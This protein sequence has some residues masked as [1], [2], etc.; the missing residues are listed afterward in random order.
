MRHA[1]TMPLA[2]LAG[3]AISDVAF[4]LV[5]AAIP[6]T[7]S[8]SSQPG[9]DAVSVV[10][11]QWAAGCV[12]FRR[13]WPLA[14]YGAAM[15]ALVPSWVVWGAPEGLGLLLPLVVLGYAL[16]R[17]AEG[18]RAYVGLG[19]LVTG[20]ALHDVLDPLVDSLSAF[21]GAAV[22]DALGVLAWVAGALVR[23]GRIGAVE[24]RGRRALEER[25]RLARELHDLIAHGMSVMVIQAEAAAEMIEQGDPGRAL[26]AIGRVQAT[27]REGLAEVRRLVAVLRGEEAAELAPQPGVHQLPVL[28]RQADGAGP[29][30]SLVESGEPGPIADGISLALYRIA[31][32]AITNALRHANASRIDVRMDYDDPLEL[33]IA[34]DGTARPGAP[35]EP[36]LG[37]RGMR[38]RA[39]LYGGRLVA[40]PGES[41]GFVVVASIPRDGLR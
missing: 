25:T 26:T 33:R 17:Y 37:I 39:V 34:D 31:Q 4:A 24:R 9:P 29:A 41:G 6:L 10:T 13:R 20:M 21:R 7:D 36:G 27:G 14:A 28:V 19:V 18:R 8:W 32:E 16:G 1:L 23:A 22:F 30:V 11:A 12:V 2:S 15:A 40:A 3:A 5:L 38:E 35:P